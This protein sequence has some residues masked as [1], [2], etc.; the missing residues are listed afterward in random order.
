VWGANKTIAS[1]YRVNFEVSS[2]EVSSAGR[3][4]KKMNR[5]GMVMMIR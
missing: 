5:K 1:F 4:E 2:G 3:E